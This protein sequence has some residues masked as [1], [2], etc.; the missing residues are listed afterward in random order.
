MQNLR[1]FSRV[2]AHY[3]KPGRLRS[4]SFTLRLARQSTTILRMEALLE[5]PAIRE[6]I[7]RLSVDEYHRAGEAGILS[8]NVELLRGIVVTKMSRSP[9][10]AIVGQKL[11]NRLNALK[12]KGFQLRVE[13]PLTIGDSEPEPDLCLVR[14]TE[15]DWA[16]AHPSRAE[17]VIEIAI[18]S[19]QV[20]TGKADIYAEAVVPE[21][22]LFRPEDR[23]VDV[24]RRPVNGR[25]LSRATLLEPAILCCEAIPE[26]EIELSDV[27]PA[28]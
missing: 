15:D 10:H 6:R 20:D 8:R 28:K 14:G 19:V 16:A 22:W 12:P 13:K 25:Y 21:Y 2:N 9:V 11:E 1:R 18:N 3:C 24:Y 26:I 4:I 17:L 5:M 27:F 23:A 7:H